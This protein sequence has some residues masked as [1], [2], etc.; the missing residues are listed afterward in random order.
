MPLERISRT[1]FKFIHGTNLVYNQCWEDPRLDRIALEI[2]PQ[3]NIAVITSAGCNAL[4]YVLAG[5]N[6]VYAI[7][8]NHRQNALLELKRAGTQALEFEDFFALFGAG[9]LANWKQIYTGSLRPRLPEYA[10]KFWDRHGTFFMGSKRRPSFYF[11]GTSGL[12]AWM[13]NGY[14]NK[15]ARIRRSVNDILD[16]KTLEEQQEIYYGAR[17]KESLFR[18]MVQWLLRRDTTMAM[19]GV[20][21]SQRKQLDECYPGGIVQFIVDRIETVFAKIPLADNYFWRV[22]L[23][24]QYTHDCCPEYLKEDNFQRLKGGLI[25]KVSSHTNSLL[26]FLEGHAEPISRF[27]LLDHMDWLYSNYREVLAAE[28]QGIVD[29]AA[30]N[31]KVIWRSAGLEVD[32]V[33]PIEVKRNGE[34]VPMRELLNYHPAL[35]AKLHTIDRVNTY[36][37]FYIADL[38]V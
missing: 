19:L 11:R 10:Q 38:S 25:E 20:P 8:M 12:F 35:A 26:G 31:A 7:D 17:L 14:I 33:D 16:A 36:G 3:D 2:S 18:P 37:S 27:V 6:H 28:W 5:A 32:F 23:T 30:E 22:Y 15:V 24:G 1:C 29:R 21:R 34:T 9:R 4:D 13:V